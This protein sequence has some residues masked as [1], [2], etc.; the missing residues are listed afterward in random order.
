MT[1][2]NVSKRSAT[3]F[4]SVIQFQQNRIKANQP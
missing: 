3:L 4:C 2:V 1:L